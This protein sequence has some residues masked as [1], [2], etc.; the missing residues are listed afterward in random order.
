[1]P[2]VPTCICLQ[3]CATSCLQFNPT[4]TGLSNGCAILGL[5]IHLHRMLKNKSRTGFWDAHTGPS[6]FY[7]V[8]FQS[9]CH[10][11]CLDNNSPKPSR[12]CCATEAYL[13]SKRTLIS[14]P[15]PDKKQRCFP[16]VLSDNWCQELCPVLFQTGTLK[17]NI[18]FHT[19]AD[20]ADW[21][22]S[23]EVGIQLRINLAIDMWWCSSLHH[24]GCK[25]DPVSFTALRK[26]NNG[27]FYLALGLPQMV[28][29]YILL[30]A[31][32]CR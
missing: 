32:T 13:V 2:I 27:R 6:P 24:T 11:T 26:Q 20:L 30:E 8:M 23:Y 12:F 15:L 31:C 22:G 18:L 7:T 19:R 9:L 14:A 4:I 28:L 1:M 5:L 3:F 29:D 17:H 21:N 25:C 16:V 10:I